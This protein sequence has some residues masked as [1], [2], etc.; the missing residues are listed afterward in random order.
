MVVRGLEAESSQ[1]L[2]HSGRIFRNPYLDF[3]VSVVKQ[4]AVM[5]LLCSTIECLEKCR[6]QLCFKLFAFVREFCLGLRL[7][8]RDTNGRRRRCWRRWRRGSSN[9]RNN[10]NFRAGGTTCATSNTRTVTGMSAG[11]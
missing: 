5:A 6:L 3:Y 8:A 4:L 1:F 7:V 10:D 9:S 11:R 2:D